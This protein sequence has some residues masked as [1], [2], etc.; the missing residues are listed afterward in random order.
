MGAFSGRI[1]VDQPAHGS[2]IAATRVNLYKWR[3]CRRD[4]L[5]ESFGRRLARLRLYFYLDRARAVALYGTR[6]PYT[7]GIFSRPCNRFGV[8][9]QLLD[10]IFT[11]CTSSRRSGVDEECRSSL[12]VVPVVPV[13]AVVPAVVDVAAELSDR[14]RPVTVTL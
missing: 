9:G 10:T 13:V 2:R 12:V 7:G 8:Y 6:V 11:E 1:T 3:A 4:D 5:S 14:S